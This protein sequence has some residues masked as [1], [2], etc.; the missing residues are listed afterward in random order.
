MPK[1]ILYNVNFEFSF[2]NDMYSYIEKIKIV[3]IK[4]EKVIWLNKIEK[5][6]NGAPTI[7]IIVLFLLSILIY[8]IFII[9]IITPFDYFNF[10]ISSAL[11]KKT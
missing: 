3:K 10:N 11:I 8:L 9:F 6:I 4:I 2:I 5:I 1:I 7:L